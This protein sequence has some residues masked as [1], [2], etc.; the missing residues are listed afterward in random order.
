M[1]SYSCNPTCRYWFN[2]KNTAAFS[3]FL[4][5]EKYLLSEGGLNY[6]IMSNGIETYDI[7]DNILPNATGIPI[8]FQML[9]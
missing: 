4:A 5:L 2:L 7:D 1:H 3:F 8:R 6:K 9:R